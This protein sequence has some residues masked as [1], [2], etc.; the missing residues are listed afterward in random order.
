MAS[1]TFTFDP[2]AG[3]L[4]AVSNL[5]VSREH[6]CDCGAQFT[7]TME[8]PENLTYEGAISLKQ[9]QCP[10]CHQPVLLPK[11]RYWVEAFQLRSEPLP[12]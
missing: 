3:T 5:Q 7:F 6:T 9:G 11:A 12:G 1:N 4:S 2:K 8:W 10:M